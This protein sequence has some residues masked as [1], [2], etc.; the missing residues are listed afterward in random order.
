MRVLSRQ[1]GFVGEEVHMAATTS[2]VNPRRTGFDFAALAASAGRQDGAEE[3]ARLRAALETLAEL[4]IAHGV[5]DARTLESIVGDLIRPTPAAAAAPL[6]P[7]AP[8]AAE[9][10]A[11]GIAAKAPAAVAS[12][13]AKTV[14]APAPA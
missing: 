8:S 3:V 10:T 5:M 1:L 11:R 9:A 4:V 7:P 2:N 12:P 6:P 14:M 13:A